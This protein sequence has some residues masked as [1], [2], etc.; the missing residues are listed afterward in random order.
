M[1]KKLKLGAN[2]LASII[3]H[4]G[5]IAIVPDLNRPIDGRPIFVVELLGGETKSSQLTSKNSN[6]NTTTLPHA[7]DFSERHTLDK[8][9][10]RNPEEITDK[11]ESYPIKTVFG[12]KSLDLPL[13]PL[14]PLGLEPSGGYSHNVKGH[15]ILGL[16]I[17][18]MGIVRWLAVDDS[19][20]TQEINDRIS[21]SF[22]QLQFVP[23]K[24]HGMPVRVLMR[25][26]VRINP[27]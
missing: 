1:D 5:I 2:L 9:S 22:T 14:S 18:E 27:E 20:L 23:P 3:I 11:T 26:E 10:P 13:T 12:S 15:T 8:P 25:I 7:A 6:H 19:N 24:Q 21:R 17:D 16:L 4:G